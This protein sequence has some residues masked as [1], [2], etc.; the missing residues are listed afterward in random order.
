MQDVRYTH[1]LETTDAQFFSHLKI[2]GALGRAFAAARKSGDAAAA[3]AAVAEHFR[4]RSAPSVFFYCHGA[5]WHETDA[6]GRVLDKAALLLKNK[7]RNSWPPHHVVPLTGR[8]GKLDFDQALTEAGSATSRHTFVTELSTAWALTGK[9]LYIRKAVE[10]MQAFVA[11]A[12]FEL[13]PKFLEDHD[14][15]F[16]GRGNYTLSV[17]Y[18]AFRW[19][20]FLYCG[21]L[22]APGLVSDAEVVWIVKQIWFWAMQYYRL[23]GDVLRRDNH[24]LVDHGHSQF[25]FGM[26]FPEFDV[27]AKLTAYGAKVIRFHGANNLL[28]DGGNA[29]HSAEYQ[30]HITYHYLHPL[31][32]AQA[33][34][35]PLFNAKTRGLI[36]KWAEFNAGLAMPDGAIPPIGD[37]AGR[38]YHHFFGRLAVPVM[39]PRLAA[40][41]RGVGCAPGAASVIAAPEVARKLHGW[42]SGTPP[43]IG[44]AP[45]YL[46]A[47]KIAPPDAKQ[48][49]AAASVQFPQGGY[50]V[51]R[52][53]WSPDSDYLAM[54]HF[55]PELLGGHAHFDPLSFVLYSG[56]KLLIGDPATWL[57]FDP[58]FFGHGGGKVRPTAAKV[59]YHRGYSYGADSHNVFVRNFDFIRPLRALSHFSSYGLDRNPLCGLGLFEA[60]GPIELAEAWH[61]E[62]APFRHHRFLV[63]LRGLGFVFIDRM[64]SRKGKLSPHDYTQAYHA[65]FDLVVAPLKPPVDGALRIGSG[66]ASCLMVPGRETE[67]RWEVFRD[68]YLTGVYALGRKPG[69]PNPWVAELGRQVRGDVVFA[70]FVLT[71]AGREAKTVPTARYL[72]VTPAPWMGWQTDGYTANALDLGA[73]G[74]LYVASCPYHRPVESK[75]FSTDGELA[76]VHLDRR[77]GVVAWAL[78]RGSRLVVRGRSLFKG[79]KISWR[80]G[81]K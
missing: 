70:T 73:H 36:G 45:Y 5:P 4:T 28:P 68:E 65:D 10:L 3:V 67:T 53:K 1:Q 41:G 61:D 63:H 32:I 48:L 24:H 9:P 44:L 72:G 30:Y 47:G 75:E 11:A 20:D 69:G 42:R 58:R 81:G 8:G 7:L 55:S 33:N 76:V 2:P 59:Q 29:E 31:G 21:A 49:P 13:D 66:A 35:F 56:G 43:Q 38:T 46:E 19:V 39:T 54:S 37:S 78:A 80:N 27:S 74:T 15:Y 52:E 22:Q 79:K 51:L 18:R 50:T 71:H 77:G 12:P 60:G 57:Y 25:F 17:C 62:F 40:M 14:A 64:N 16:G 26:M 23:V 34:R 6:P